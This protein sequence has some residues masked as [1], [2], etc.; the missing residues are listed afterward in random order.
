MPRNLDWRVETM[1]LVR[2]ATVHRQVLDQI[3]V[4]NIKDV[5]QSWELQPDGSYRRLQ[6]GDVSF[7]AHRFFMTNPSLSGR[8]SALR[9]QIRSGNLGR[10]ASA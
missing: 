2:N 4:A 8:G 7:S 3:M 9:K 1:V 10:T 6:V 5:D